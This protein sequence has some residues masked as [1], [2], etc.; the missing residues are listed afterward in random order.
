MKI[1]NRNARSGG[2]I[3][4]THTTVDAN[5]VGKKFEDM[6]ES[7]RQYFKQAMDDIGGG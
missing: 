4:G 6:F 3:Q 5:R 1:I 7:A 2:S